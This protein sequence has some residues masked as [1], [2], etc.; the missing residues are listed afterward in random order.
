MVC[1]P[2]HGSRPAGR[3]GLTAAIS[4]A[5]VDHAA[6]D[7]AAVNPGGS[8]GPVVAAAPAEIDAPDMDLDT[9]EEVSWQLAISVMAAWRAAGGDR[10]AVSER[11]AE[12]AD[13]NGEAAA[14]QAAVGLANVAGMFIELYADRLGMSPDV[15]LSDVS[16]LSRDRNL[17]G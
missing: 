3:S 16:T 5:A 10:H 8:A 17:Y 11:L 15:V 6:V 1:P 13:T 12:A 9:D 2:P 4:H 14:E 7:H